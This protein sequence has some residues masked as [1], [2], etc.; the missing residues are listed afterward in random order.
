MQNDLKAIINTPSQDDSAKVKEIILSAVIAENQEESESSQVCQQL[1]AE[2]TDAKPI[3]QW[4]KKKRN[5]YLGQLN[6]LGAI[7]AD[8]ADKVNG[9]REATRTAFFM[10]SD[11]FFLETKERKAMVKLAL[12]TFNAND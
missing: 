9:I 12:G 6:A 4:D 5:R 3:T 8:I 1:E 10:P 11:K 7:H 2:L